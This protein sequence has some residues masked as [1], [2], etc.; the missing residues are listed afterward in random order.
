MRMLQMKDP[1]DPRAAH[2][3]VHICKALFCF[4]GS[5]MTFDI[6]KM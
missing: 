1:R 6:T 4:I 2:F 5:R 3:Q